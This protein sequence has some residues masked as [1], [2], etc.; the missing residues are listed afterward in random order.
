MRYEN[1]TFLH[2]DWLQNVTYKT[3]VT[4]VVLQKQLAFSIFWPITMQNIFYASHLESNYFAPSEREDHFRSVEVRF[5]HLHD[6][7]LLIEKADTYGR[8]EIT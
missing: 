8:F 4:K 1:N 3:P 2:N 5:S 6:I 7:R